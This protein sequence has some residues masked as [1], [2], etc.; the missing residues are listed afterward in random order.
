[1]LLMIL[2]FSA[3]CATYS[4]ITKNKIEKEQELVVYT[5][6]GEEYRII[7]EKVSQDT[8]YGKTLTFLK[9]A[10][11]IAIKDI[12]T[13]EK[14]EMDKEETIGTVVLLLIVG[15]YIVLELSGWSLL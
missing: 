10:I 11:A 13:V 12:K 8:L 2:I 6:N 15:G 5:R 14:V 3:S 1:M 7:S 4:T 9:P